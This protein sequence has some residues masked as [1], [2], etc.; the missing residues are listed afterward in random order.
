MENAEHFGLIH[1][2]PPLSFAQLLPAAAK[3]FRDLCIVDIGLH[4]ADLASLNLTPYHKSVHRPFDVVRIIFLSLQNTRE[5]KELVKR[6]ATRLGFE[7]G[8]HMRK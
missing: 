3:T 8:S 7:R 4:L 2:G 6:L 1:E 5:M